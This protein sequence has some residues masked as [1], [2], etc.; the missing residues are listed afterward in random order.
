MEKKNHSLCVFTYSYA[1]RYKIGVH[2]E[3][4]TNGHNIS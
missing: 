2:V 1:E 3:E 4:I